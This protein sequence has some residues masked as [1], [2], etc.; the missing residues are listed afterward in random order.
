M[1][2]RGRNESALLVALSDV[3]RDYDFVCYY[4]DK[5]TASIHPNS[6][7]RSNAYKLQRCTI[8]S[9]V[10]AYNILDIFLSEPKIG[11][12]NPT[13]P[14][15]AYYSKTLGNEWSQNF[16]NTLA[17]H[18]KLG[19][20]API[21]KNKEPVASYGSVFWFRT[22]ALKLLFERGWEYEDFPEEPI[23]SDASLLHAIERIY[24]YVSQSAGYYP[25]YILSDRAAELEVL[26]LRESLRMVNK[27]AGKNGVI[28]TLGAMLSHFNYQL[29]LGA[30]ARDII[31]DSKHLSLAAFIKAKIRNFK[32]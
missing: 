6:I 18:K 3:C 30:K 29:F 4:H 2:N 17:L 1:E 16:E 8:P 22:K 25:A 27:F 12:L 26:N 5:K 20:R 15:H 28:D 21:D 14:N 32:K 24:P 13:E 9:S 23:K 10:F 7:G 19:L 31:E 11:L